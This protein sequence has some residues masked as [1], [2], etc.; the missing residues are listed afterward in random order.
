[1]GGWIDRGESAVSCFSE[2][3][4]TQRT[5]LSCLMAQ[6]CTNLWARCRGKWSPSP[7]D[8][9]CY[10]RRHLQSPCPRPPGLL[11]CVQ[12]DRWQCEPQSV[13]F[14]AAVL[15]G[16]RSQ[17]WQVLGL[18]C[19]TVCWEF[20]MQVELEAAQTLEAD[21]PQASAGALLSALY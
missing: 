15:Q 10:C 6:G 1:M 8:M 19:D 14:H 9:V 16:W 12:G 17:S 11:V 18:L 20:C 2:V 21:I 5:K 13:P 3:C 4:L 7:P